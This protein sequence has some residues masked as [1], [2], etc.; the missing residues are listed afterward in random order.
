M[1]DVYVDIQ[2]AGRD[3]MIGYVDRL[4][5][6]RR[7]DVAL[8]SGDF[9]VGNRDIARFIDAVGRV[10]HVAV[11]EEKVVGG[12]GHGRLQVWRVG[13]VIVTVDRFVRGGHTHG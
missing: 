4:R 12:G 8:D 9:A 11:L 6:Q 3:V 13:S 7:I 5:R 2:Q 1:V 10:D